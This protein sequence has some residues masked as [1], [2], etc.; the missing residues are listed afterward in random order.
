MNN[1][2]VREKEMEERIKGWVEFNP[3]ILPFIRVF[4]GKQKQI[5]KL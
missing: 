2:R 5:E 1:L 4:G 3:D